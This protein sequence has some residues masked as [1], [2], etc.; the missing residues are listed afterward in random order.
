MCLSFFIAL[1]GGLF[2]GSKYSN[3]KS[4]LKAYDER[5]AI[6]E[7]TYNDVQSRHV[8]SY[9]TEQGKGL[10]T[11]CARQRLE[12]KTAYSNREKLTDHG[13]PGFGYPIGGIN[14]KDISIKFAGRCAIIQRIG[15]GQTTS[16]SN[17]LNI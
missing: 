5:R 13:I 9:D 4:K 2:Y 8:A 17:Y 3:E 1:F 12:R 15:C 11:I 6:H 16:K 14:D 7:A 10:R